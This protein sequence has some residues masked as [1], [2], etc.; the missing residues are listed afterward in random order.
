MVEDDFQRLSTLKD[1]SGRENESGRIGRKD[2][3]TGAYATE[4]ELARKAQEVPEEG[5]C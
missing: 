3:K 4:L 2:C 1:E 5:R